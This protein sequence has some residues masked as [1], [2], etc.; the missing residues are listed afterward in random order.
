MPVELLQR[1]GIQSDF[2]LKLFYYFDWIDDVLSS[3]VSRA[4]ASAQNI[5]ILSGT[6]ERIGIFKISANIGSHFKI[7]HKNIEKNIKCL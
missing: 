6:H 2:E 3:E 4:V 7:S 5:D 1:W